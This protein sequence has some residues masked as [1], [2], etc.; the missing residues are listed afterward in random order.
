MPNVKELEQK[1]TR[2]VSDKEVS[3]DEFEAMMDQLEELMESEEFFK[4]CDRT[5]SHPKLY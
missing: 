2:A 3:D 5:L 1:I 4:F